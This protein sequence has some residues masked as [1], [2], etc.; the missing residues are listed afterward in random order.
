MESDSIVAFIPMASVSAET[1]EARSTELRQFKHLSSGLTYF[2][3]GDILVA[4][5]TPCF[6][7]GKIAQVQIEQLHGF[8]STEFHVVRPKRDRI[9]DRYSFHFLRQPKVRL[10]GQRR[11]TG[12]AGQRRVPRDFIENLVVALP[13]LPEQHRIATILDQ[14]EA[15]RIEAP[16]DCDNTGRPHPIYISGDVW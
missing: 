6:E 8:G 1:G 15:L 16:Q 14:A 3:N 11:M 4:K 7:N 2:Q 5:I 9:H 10:E 12:S 13:P